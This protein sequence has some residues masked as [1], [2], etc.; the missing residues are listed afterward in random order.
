MKIIIIFCSYSLCVLVSNATNCDKY[1]TVYQSSII[2]EGFSVAVTSWSNH[3]PIT[4]PPPPPPPSTGWFGEWSTALLSSF[5]DKTG[6]PV[7]T[8][9]IT[10]HV[11]H[12]TIHYMILVRYSNIHCVISM[13]CG[14]R[15]GNQSL[16]QYSTYFLE[17]D[18][19]PKYTILI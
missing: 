18:I 9:H 3:P 10:W 8:W 4:I 6:E 5:T 17:Q 13:H 15:I 2:T 7:I 16:L 11:S 14:F 19:A 12:M 1:W